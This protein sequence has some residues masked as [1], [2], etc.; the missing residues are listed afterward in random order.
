MATSDKIPYLRHRTGDCQPS[1][2]PCY[3]SPPRAFPKRHPT[4]ATPLTHSPQDL[5]PHLQRRQRCPLRRQHPA[6]GA[7]VG[8]TAVAGPG[9]GGRGQEARPGLR[10]KREKTGEAGGCVVEVCADCVC[11]PSQKGSS[12][13]SAQ[14]AYRA[15]P[16]RGQPSSTGSRARYGSTCS[17]IGPGPGPAATKP[18][19]ARRQPQSPNAY[20]APPRTAAAWPTVATQPNTPVLQLQQGQTMT[21]LVFTRTSAAGPAAPATP[22][23]HTVTCA[24]VVQHNGR[25]QYGSRQLGHST[26]SSADGLTPVA[27]VAPLIIDGVKVTKATLYNI[28]YVTD[29]CS[30]EWVPWSGTH[31]QKCG[32]VLEGA[33]VASWL[34]A[35]HGHAVQALLCRTPPPAEP[36]AKAAL[37]S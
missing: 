5:G 14:F 32:R 27:L 35:A 30:C 9:G 21:C 1:G 23:A 7:V 24:A 29:L 8:L 25:G 28:H 3:W 26:N 2:P 19:L 36:V 22:P 15:T 11:L 31:G 4:M 6:R 37:D 17:R 34:A 16:S 20:T 13:L 33:C 10:V 12:P 18:G